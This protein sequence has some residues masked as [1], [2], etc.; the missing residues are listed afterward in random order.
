MI[1][2]RIDVGKKIWVIVVL[3]REHVADFVDEEHKVLSHR[4]RRVG[5]PAG[6]DVLASGRP[7]V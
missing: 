6:A 4:Q 7:T 5:I 1:G 2:R 3:L